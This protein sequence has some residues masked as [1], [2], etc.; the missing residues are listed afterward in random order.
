MKRGE[1]CA[2]CGAYLPRTELHPVGSMEM[3]LPTYFIPNTTFYAPLRVMDNH[4]LH[5][6]PHRGPPCKGYDVHANLSVHIPGSR[7]R[8]ISFFT[9]RYFPLGLP[10]GEPRR[11]RRT[12]GWSPLRDDRGNLTD[13]HPHVYEWLPREARDDFSLSSL[14]RPHTDTHMGGSSDEE[15][16]EEESDH[17][18]EG[19]DGRDPGGATRLGEDAPAAP[20]HPAAHEATDAP[21]AATGP[22]PDCHNLHLLQRYQPSPNCSKWSPK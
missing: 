15:D 7:L 3:M 21:V 19:G 20:H 11:S 16:E 17:G 8:G 6:D 1:A 22:P 14:L 4:P 12:S 10:E 18:G 5:A 9:R 2:F 13:E